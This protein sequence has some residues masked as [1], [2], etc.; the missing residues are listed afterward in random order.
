MN[1]VSLFLLQV[2]CLDLLSDNYNPLNIFLLTFILT[3]FRCIF[4]GVHD[5]TIHQLEQEAG[6]TGKKS[7]LPTTLKT[8]AGAFPD[9]I[10]DFGRWKKISDTAVNAAKEYAGNRKKSSAAPSSLDMR[11]A[12]PEI[13][14]GHL[15]KN[16]AVA[17]T[18]EQ[19]EILE[20]TTK[21]MV[22]Y[23]NIL[24]HIYC[25]LVKGRRIV[26]DQGH[27]LVGPVSDL[28]VSLPR[29]CLG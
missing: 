5:V 21:V 4:N 28:Q 8:K 24:V 10:H 19:G 23:C 7:V 15:A 22:L 18:S 3:L 11:T 26:L 17:V 25:L 20:L 16:V 27:L 29:M 1:F 12:E 6:E 14:H 2:V 13:W 9:S